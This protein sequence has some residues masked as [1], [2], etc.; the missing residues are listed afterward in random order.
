MKEVPLG[1]MVDVALRGQRVVKERRD[2]LVLRYVD[3]SIVTAVIVCM[4]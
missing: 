2:P 1:P 3:I 4:L